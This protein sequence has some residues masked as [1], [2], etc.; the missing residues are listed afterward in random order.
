MAEHAPITKEDEW[1]TGEDKTFRFTVRDS[2]G[3]IQVLTGWEVEWVLRKHRSAAGDPV[4]IKDNDPGTAPVDA[5]IT[6]GPGGKVEVYI[7]RGDTDDLNPGT[8]F[9]TLRRTDDGSSSV[10]AYG[11]AV[12]QQAA[13]R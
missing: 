9:H 4:L 12:L 2:A 8:Y 1:F 3:A 7:R 5:A 6:D 13:T 11:E 10:L